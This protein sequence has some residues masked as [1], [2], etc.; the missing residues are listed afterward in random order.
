MTALAV[1]GQGKE[2]TLDDHPGPDVFYVLASRWA[3]SQSD[4][5]LVGLLRDARPSES[6]CGGGLERDLAGPAPSMAARRAA[7]PAPS[8]SD[9]VRGF[10]L[11]DHGS[12]EPDLGLSVA[13]GPDGIVVLRIPIQH[14]AR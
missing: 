11:T 14:M 10:G 13:A 12:A 2:F 8:A 3:L 1:P 4:P 6:G 7:P 9:A 5:T